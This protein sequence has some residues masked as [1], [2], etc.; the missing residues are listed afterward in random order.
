MGDN[1]NFKNPFSKP[2]S[3]PVIPLSI[4]NPN[5]VKTVTTK[6]VTRELGSPTVPAVKKADNPIVKHE[7]KPAFGLPPEP[8]VRERRLW[9]M[10][11]IIMYY[12]F[13]LIKFSPFSILNSFFTSYF[14]I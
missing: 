3:R 13:A 9:N 4:G 7:I 12:I 8:I 11:N 10:N 5:V 2:V 1:S 6:I 14:S